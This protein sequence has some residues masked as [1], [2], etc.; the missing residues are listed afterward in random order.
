MKK[1]NDTT[2]YTAPSKELTCLAML[3]NP[4]L[5]HGG[6]RAKHLHGEFIGQQGVQEKGNVIHPPLE[7]LR[8]L[9]VLGCDKIQV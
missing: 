1:T 4:N 8:A 2:R 3:P 5:K 7:K 6:R 9:N